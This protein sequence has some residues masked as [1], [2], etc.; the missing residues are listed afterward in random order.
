VG[1]FGPALGPDLSSSLGLILAMLSGAMQA[2]APRLSFGVVDVRD[3]A[4][5]HV[6]AITHPAAVG[7]R[8][9]ASAGDAISLLEGEASSGLGATVHGGGPDS[10]R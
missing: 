2:G 5:L 10:K 7:E 8:F 4:E 1:I 9:I 3:V 6:L